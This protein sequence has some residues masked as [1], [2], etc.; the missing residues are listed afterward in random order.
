MNLLNRKVPCLQVV[1]KNIVLDRQGSRVSSSGASRVA[2][3]TVGDE[4]GVI[5][6]VAKNEQGKLTVVA[7]CG[8]L[9]LSIRMD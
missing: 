7:F 1:D 5:V 8:I 3:C 6:F 9:V 2:E 4:T